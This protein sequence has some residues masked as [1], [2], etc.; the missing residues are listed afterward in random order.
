[1]NEKQDL[2]N[3]IRIVLNF[4]QALSSN[5][6]YYNPEYKG[7]GDK[8]YVYLRLERAV[9]DQAHGERATSGRYAIWTREIRLLIKKALEELEYDK[10]D[11]TKEKL[12]LALNALGAFEDIMTVF[13]VETFS[14]NNL[15]K[16]I[17][18]EG[19][20]KYLARKK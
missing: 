5:E 16:K 12:I 1:M 10:L 19:Y 2:I 8:Y 14:H 3:G 13:D 6:P 18:F 15:D 11:E 20:S 4:Y 17:I 7:N 9:I